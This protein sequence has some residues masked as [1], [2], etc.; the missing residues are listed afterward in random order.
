MMI[1][2]YGWRTF[3]SFGDPP[4]ELLKPEGV[5]LCNIFEWFK[6]QYREGYDW[7]KL[8]EHLY[9]KIES[10]V[11]F[12]ELHGFKILKLI[13]GTKLPAVKWA[14]KTWGKDLYK[15]PSR[16]EVIS[17]LVKRSKYSP[18][19]AVG[20]IAGRSGFLV[21]DLDRKHVRREDNFFRYFF[22]RTLTAK[23][24]SGGRHVYFKRDLDLRR[25]E[26]MEKI[27]I[28]ILRM[29]CDRLR[30]L[31]RHGNGMVVI[32]PTVLTLE[33]AKHYKRKQRPGKYEWIDRE[34]PILP[35]SEALK[36]AKA[37]LK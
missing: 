31:E 2:L 10:E 35:F 33:A 6:S 17:W 4:T 23:T 16:E 36:R 29:N 14:K 26:P 34:K 27:K 37:I 20:C 8:K 24:P 7:P 19:G 15:E 22:D 21:A 13:P 25:L 3:P 9:D 1:R 30:G 28:E 32:P 5:P 18:I 11:D 12:F